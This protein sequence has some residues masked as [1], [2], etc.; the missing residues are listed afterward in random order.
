MQP[1]YLPWIGFFDLIDAVD[2]F[3]LLDNVKVEKSSWQTRN[4]LR[5]SSGEV[6]LTVPIS[7]PKGSL[8]TLINEATID[9]KKPWIKKH[10]RTIE[11]NYSKSIFFPYF[12]PDVERILNEKYVYLSDLNAELISTMC[13]YI[14]IKTKILKASALPNFKE[15]KQ[16]R[17]LSICQHLKV[18]EYYSPKG[19]AVYL[20]EGNHGGIL[21]DH[22]IKVIYQ[23]F[24]TLEYKQRFSPFIAYLSAIDVIFNLGAKKT[25]QLI[26]NGRNSIFQD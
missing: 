3:V 8:Y 5:S 15:V 22:N 12:Y 17:L 6:L 18:N 2:I 19:S 9:Y 13:S 25:K 26:E 21:S 10:L 20:D 14:G 24:V 1:T 7:T 4:R 11:Q 16:E 23:D